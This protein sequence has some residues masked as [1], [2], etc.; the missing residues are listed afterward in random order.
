MKNQHFKQANIST[1]VVFPI[2]VE[3]EDGESETY[4]DIE[5]LVCDLEDFDSDLDIACRVRDK[6]GRLVRLKLKTLDLKELSIA[7]N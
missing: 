3:F 6:L 2:T 1:D 5:H 4:D 7:A